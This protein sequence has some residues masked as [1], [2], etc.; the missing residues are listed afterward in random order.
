[1]INHKYGIKLQQYFNLGWTIVILSV[2]FIIYSISIWSLKMLKEESITNNNMK[3][4]LNNKKLNV[5]TET[6]ELIINNMSEVLYS[7]EQVNS[8]LGDINECKDKATI[9]ISMIAA[10]EMQNSMNTEEL[11]SECKSVNKQIFDLKKYF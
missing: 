6:N 3:E 8:S 11:L 9:S 10:S 2:G 7:I 4:I 1:M 5:N